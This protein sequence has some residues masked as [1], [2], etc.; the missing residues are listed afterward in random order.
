LTSTFEL[1]IRKS[2]ID[3]RSYPNPPKIVEIVMEGV[4]ILM[5]VKYTWQAA[6]ALM[7]DLNLFI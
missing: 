4:A 7:Q 1:N 5:G 6:K 3:M 2:L